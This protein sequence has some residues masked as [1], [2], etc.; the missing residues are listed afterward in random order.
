MRHTCK[1]MLMEWKLVLGVTVLPVVAAPA[2]AQEAPSP[3]TS[4][5]VA[6]NELAKEISNP[7]TSLWQLQLQFNNMR[8][9]TGNAFPTDGKWA[10]NLY[11]QPV[12]PISLTRGLNLITRPVITAYNSV[13][14]PSGP[15][16]TDRKTTFGDM[17]MANVLSPAGTAPWIFGIGPTWIF[18]TAGSDLTGQGKWQVGPAVGGGYITNKFMIAT[19]AQQWWS[20]AGGDDRESTSQLSLLPLIYYFFGEGWSVGYS[21]N[22]VADWKAQGGEKWTVPLGL[23][24]G[25]VV[26]LGKLPVQFQVAGQHFVERPTGGPRWN[27]QFQVTP[28]IPKL[29]RGT[30]F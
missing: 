6:A 28:V 21:G 4:S 19:F 1:A 8:L 27:L 9:E 18:P 16:S 29:I 12:M 15:F 24:V 3:E 13:P 17:T 7:V 20:F 10:N 2:S 25:K 23:S 5:A 22:P 30:L 14:Y 26:F 11:F